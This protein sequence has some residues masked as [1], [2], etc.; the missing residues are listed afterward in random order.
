MKCNMLLGLADDAVLVLEA[1]IRY[2]QK[3]GA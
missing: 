1:A 2:L 3:H